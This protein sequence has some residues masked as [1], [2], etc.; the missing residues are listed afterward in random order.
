MCLVFLVFL[1]F[2][3][4]LVGCGGELKGPSG[5]F[6]SPNYPEPH[7]SLQE[8]HWTITV[9]P[10]KKIEL[11]ILDFDIEAHPSCQFDQLQVNFDSSQIFLIS[12][13]DS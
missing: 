2:P 10:D 13:F 8:C 12:V 6:S 11:N 4:E 7:N 9:D 1:S 5:N 3:S